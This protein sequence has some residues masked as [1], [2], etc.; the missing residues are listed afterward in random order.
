MCP[1]YMVKLSMVLFFIRHIINLKSAN[2]KSHKFQYLRKPLW[3]STISE[4][5]A[6]Y[7]DK[8]KGIFFVHS[9]TF[10]LVSSIPHLRAY[11]AS[12]RQKT[13]MFY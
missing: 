4:I 5:W 2:K 9:R 10:F 7:V 13:N 3:F 1:W 12:Y 11:L 6:C 8:I